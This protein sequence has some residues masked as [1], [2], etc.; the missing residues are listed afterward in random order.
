MPLEFVFWS[1]ISRNCQICHQNGLL[2]AIFSSSSLPQ[3]W[4]PFHC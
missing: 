4:L 3:A 1:R 2:H